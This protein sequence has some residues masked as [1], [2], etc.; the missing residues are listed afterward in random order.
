MDEKSGSNAAEKIRSTMQ[1]SPAMAWLRG[2]AGAIV[3]GAIGYY[4]FGLLLSQGYY[5]LALPAASL[6]LGF[7]L[8]SGRSMIS[9]ALFCGVCG[10]GLM[11][12][13]EW[14]TSPFL[15]DES[16]SYFVTNLLSL[17][18][19]TKVFLGLGTALAFWFGSRR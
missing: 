15:K 16:L 5:G 19:V 14:S 10:L 3:G 13:C 1:V 8:A 18:I 2:I 4:V 9:G 6:G 17:K 12:Y 7:G 11:I